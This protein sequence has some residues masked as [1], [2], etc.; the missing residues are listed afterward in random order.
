MS[1]SVIFRSI[2]E[3]LKVG[4]PVI[5]QLYSC[6]TVLFSDIR[7]DR[8]VTFLNDM[9]SGFDAIIAKHDAYKVE[10]IGDAYMIVSGVPNENGNNHVKHIA[11]IALKMRSVRV[12]HPSETAV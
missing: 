9:F 3:D 12:S 6:A 1:T 4:K 7:G 11:D 2:A 10:T 8:I 5:P